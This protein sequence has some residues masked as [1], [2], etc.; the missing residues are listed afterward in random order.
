MKQ[1]HGLV[2]IMKVLVRHGRTTRPHSATHSF[3]INIK[4]KQ[5]LKLP[6][7]T[8]MA[9]DTDVFAEVSDRH[10]RCARNQGVQQ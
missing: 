1:T 7:R 8:R 3:F 10:G 4:D 2:P 5:F 9:G 6:Q